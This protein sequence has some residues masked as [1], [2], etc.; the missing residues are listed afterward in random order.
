MEAVK[1]HP[2][3]PWHNFVLFIY[4]ANNHVACTGT[5]LSILHILT[6]LPSQR[7][8]ESAGEETKTPR[9]EG[10]RSKPHSQGA[11]IEGFKPTR[12]AG[13]GGSRL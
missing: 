2:H 4:F 12:S 9:D 3:D 6:H 8:C 13:R 11:A 5:V 10:T 7:H 1:K